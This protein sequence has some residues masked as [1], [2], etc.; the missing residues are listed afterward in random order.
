MT[1]NKHGSVNQQPLYGCTSCYEECAWS[2]SDLHVHD[3]EC[4][5]DPCWDGRSEEFPDQPDWASLERFTPA[6]QAECEKLREHLQNLIDQATPLEPAPGNPMWSR[7]IQLDDVI[8]E[9]DQLRA[10]CEK[11][12]KDA[13]FGRSILSKREPGKV[14][15]CHCDL[16][17]GMEPDG[18]VIDSGERHNC[19]YAKDI[20]VKEQC[21]HWRVIAIDAA[22]QEGNQCTPQT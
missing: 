19:I 15:G 9:R 13:E 18:C 11:L 21:N 10:E 1:T 8:A 22:M 20:S 5:C 3:G 2:A 16:E 12:R 7:R 17:E 14:Y 4:W 6:L